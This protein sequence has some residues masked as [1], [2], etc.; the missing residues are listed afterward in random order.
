M[1]KVRGYISAKNEYF[2]MFSYKS[3]TSGAKVLGINSLV[4]SK[5]IYLRYRCYN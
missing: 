2:P 3:L 5:P 1:N 4:I